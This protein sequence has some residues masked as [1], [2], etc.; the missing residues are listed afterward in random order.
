M[1]VHKRF[2]KNFGIK[3]PVEEEMRRF[4]QRINQTIFKM[5]E[6]LYLYEKVFSRLCYWLGINEDDH[7][8]RK[9]E[10]TLRSLT[11]DDFLQTLEV[12]VLLHKFLDND[13]KV[14][15]TISVSVEIALSLSTID[16]GV[17]WKDGIFYKSGAKIL[18]EKL[19]ED[20]LDC[21]EDYPN[22]KR[23][24][25]KALDSYY[26]KK[27]DDVMG[28]CYLVV[29]GLARKV[30]QN[31]KPLDKN[32]EELLGKVGL[33][34]EWNSIL[35]NYIKYAHDFRHASDKR[36]SIKPQE[37]EAFLYFTGLLVRLIIESK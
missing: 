34:Q 12:L 22:V 33:S 32:Q 26:N 24:Y 15:T 1:S 21:L 2:Y 7:I 14:Q 30:L 3:V 37:V 5:V 28:S 31:K 29:E 10:S 4:V 13:S 20:P 8:R 6:G 9:H 25:L 23:D 35:Y 18:D 19:V 17:K 11:G 36:H 27:L 16:L